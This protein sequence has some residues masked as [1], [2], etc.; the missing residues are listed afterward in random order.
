MFFPL[1]MTA[2]MAIA[3]TQTFTSPMLDYLL[4]DR[5]GVV[6][7]TH[8]EFQSKHGGMDDLKAQWEGFRQVQLRYLGLANAIHHLPRGGIGVNIKISIQPYPNPPVVVPKHQPFES[9]QVQI[10]KGVKHRK[11]NEASETQG[12]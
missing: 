2:G 5:R 1:D 12:N 4:H 11:R 10:K 6:E 9:E 8:E 3:L 7:I